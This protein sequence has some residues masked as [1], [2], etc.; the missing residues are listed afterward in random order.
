MSGARIE[1]AIF[2]FPSLGDSHIMRPTLYQLSQPDIDVSPLKLAQHLAP[3]GSG[4]LRFWYP[5][6]LSCAPSTSCG[7][8]CAL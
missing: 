6:M 4:S 7:G 1:L 8:H 3:K 2:G 5:L